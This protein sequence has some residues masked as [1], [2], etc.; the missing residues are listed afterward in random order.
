MAKISQ[1]LSQ[2]GITDWV[3]RG[4][5][6]DSDEFV[7]MFKKVTGTESDGTAI[8]SSDPSLF[9]VTWAQVSA[10]LTDLDNNAALNELREQR[11]ARLSETDYL[12]LSDNTLSSNMRTY[13]QALRDLPSSNDGKN[14]TLTSDGITLENVTWPTKPTS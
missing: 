12:A 1:A 13:R 4:Q 8:E 5:P 9:G 10:K 6:T 11:N 2:L 3:V 14:A 7:S